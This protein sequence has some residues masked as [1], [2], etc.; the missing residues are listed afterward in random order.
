VDA[1]FRIV[2][3]GLGGAME[4]VCRGATSSVKYSQGA[5]IGVLPGCDPSVANPF[6]DIVIPSCDDR[7]RN[8]TLVNMADIIICVGGGAGTLSEVAFAWSLK[9]LIIAIPSTT[10]T[11][12]GQSSAS[13]FVSDRL[14]SDWRKLDGRQGSTGLRSAPF[15]EVQIAKNASEA[16]ALVV[17]YLPQC[18]WRGSSK[19]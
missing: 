12:D 9:K 14:C 2:C 11:D 10:C 13:Y 19:L 6:V 16:V 4:A 18:R 3:G 1:G 15:D 7:K 17:K 8:F 5:T